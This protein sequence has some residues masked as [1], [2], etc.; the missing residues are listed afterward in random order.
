MILISFSNKYFNQNCFYLFPNN[1]LSLFVFN[2][3]KLLWYIINYLCRMIGCMCY[4]GHCQNTAN[5]GTNIFSSY[6]LG[7]T[8]EIPSWSASYLINKFGRRP[9]LSVCFIVS[10]LAGFIYTLVPQGQDMFVFSWNKKVSDINSILTKSILQ[11]CLDFM[12]F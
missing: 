12:Y 1:F 5:L 2:I 4:Y 7:A 8:V 3:S 6:L 9:V 10:G 11:F